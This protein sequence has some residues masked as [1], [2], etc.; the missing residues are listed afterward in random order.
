MSDQDAQPERI[1][2]INQPT[3]QPHDPE[4]PVGEPSEPKPGPAPLPQPVPGP[5][6]P[7]MPR[8]AA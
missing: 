1:S 3:T 2:G 8:P 5:T 6:D 7:G 4:E